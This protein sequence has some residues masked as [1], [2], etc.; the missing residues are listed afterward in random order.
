[1]RLVTRS[2][3]STDGTWLLE[4]TPEGAGLRIRGQSVSRPQ[5]VEMA[6]RL[7]GVIEALEYTDIGARR[8]YT[9]DMVL[10]VPSELPQVALYLREVRAGAA[11]STLYGPGDLVVDP[12]APSARLS[13]RP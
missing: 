13:P 5:I 10:P 7:D 3:A 2:T 4:W 6:R 12:T 1:M 8:V 11:D 9:F